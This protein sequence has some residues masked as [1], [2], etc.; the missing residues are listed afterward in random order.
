MTLK[1]VIK[2]TSNGS[3]GLYIRKK[4]G[5]FGECIDVNY[6]S[7]FAEFVKNNNRAFELAKRTDLK[8][9]TIS[10]VNG[11]IIICVNEI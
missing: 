7:P 10:I 8:L 3:Y 6:D 9:D 4:D 2:A 11:S 5:S 1:D